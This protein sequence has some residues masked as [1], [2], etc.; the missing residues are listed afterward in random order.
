ME[1]KPSGQFITTVF[2]FENT[3]KE[4]QGKKETSI[5]FCPVLDC[6]TSKLNV[7]HYFKT[8]SKLQLHLQQ[9]HPLYYDVGINE[10][11][12][13]YIRQA[14]QALNE[15]GKKHTD[16][17]IIQGHTLT[18]IIVDKECIV[19]YESLVEK[20][21]VIGKCGHLTCLKC[22]LDG[23]KINKECLCP[24]CR[25]K[26][27]PPAPDKYCL[28]KD[29][30]CEGE[31]QKCKKCK[32]AF[33]QVHSNQCCCC[34]E[35]FCYMNADCGELTNCGS[36]TETVCYPHTKICFICDDRICKN[37]M[38]RCT[39][40]KKNVCYKHIST[41]NGLCKKC[42]DEISIVFL[43]QQQFPSNVQFESQSDEESD[44]DYVPESDVS[45]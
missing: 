22:F 7:R 24:E 4:K 32:N 11:N 35:V 42:C 28:L 21:K 38:K 2:S 26:L 5:Y 30:Y 15:K 43:Q 27:I 8:V 34:W 9:K 40:C 19:C 45:D 41:T 29:D 37:C 23:Y 6:N 20:S 18:N 17:V 25:N 16:K 14:I 44:E 36:C 3:K 10:E 1:S 31:S 12:K 33:C 39:T 13:D